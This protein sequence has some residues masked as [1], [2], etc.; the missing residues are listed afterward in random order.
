MKVSAESAEVPNLQIEG[1]ESYL[2]KPADVFYSSYDLEKE[3]RRK[4]LG[5]KVDKRGPS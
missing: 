5:G 3:R 2:K 4:I 1:A